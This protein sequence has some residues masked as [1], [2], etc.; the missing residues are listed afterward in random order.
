MEKIKVII[1]SFVTVLLSTVFYSCGKDGGAVEEPKIPSLNILSDNPMVSQAGGTATISFTCTEKWIA[2]SG[3][4]WI[5]ISPTNGLSGSNYI[6]ITATE[7]DS[8]DERN[9]NITITAGNITKNVT[10]TQKQKDALLVTSNKIEVK[11]EGG[12]ANIEVKTNVNY[13]VKVDDSCKDWVSVVSTRALS[14][15]NVTLKISE[16]KEITTREGKVSIVSGNLKED[17]SI[18]QNGT[19]PS[20]VLSQ[21]E[22][23]VSSEGDTVK[24]ELQS[25]TS[26]SV[27]MP[28]VDW[29]SESTTRAMSS[30]THY[31]NVSA[32][33]EYDSRSAK[34][35]FIDNE[36]NVSDTVKIIQAQKDAIIVANNDYNISNEAQTLEFEI[37]SNID[38]NVETSV[39]WIKHTQTR[40]LSTKKLSFSIDENVQD[41]NREGTI[42]IQSNGIK[43]T[44]NVKQE[45]A[46]MTKY[47]SRVKSEINILNGSITALLAELTI[48]EPQSED[49]QTRIDVL[50]TEL[51]DIQKHFPDINSNVDTTT[52]NTAVKALK[53]DLLTKVAAVDSIVKANG[54]NITNLRESIA[55]LNDKLKEAVANLLTLRNS[56]AKQI[57]GIQLHSA[58]CPVLS[59]T[60]INLGGIKSTFLCAY[61]GNNNAGTDEFYGLN[62]KKISLLSNAGN[63]YF[64]VQPIENFTGAEVKLINDYREEAP[65]QLTAATP[66]KDYSLQTG[67]SQ[68]AGDHV[69][70]TTA[71]YQTVAQAEAN[72]I[73]YQNELKKIASDIKTLIKKKQASGI[74][75]LVI[76]MITVAV[77]NSNAP[78]YALATEYKDANG[79]TKT[80]TTDLNIALQAVK[81]LAFILDASS[82][83]G[84]PNLYR[85]LPSLAETLDKLEGKLSIDELKEAITI[86]S[87]N[88]S[89]VT[90]KI[91]VDVSGTPTTITVDL[92]DE[93]TTHLSAKLASAIADVLND[94][95][96]DIAAQIEKSI[97]NKIST[98]IVSSK[99]LTDVHSSDRIISFLNKSIEF[100]DK[101]VDHINA[102]M[103]PVLFYGNKDMS[104]H[105]LSSLQSAPIYVKGSSMDLYASTYT[106]DILNPAFKKALVVENLTTGENVNKATF[107]NSTQKVVYDSKI[108][109]DKN[110]DG[111]YREISI[112]FPSSG[113]YKITYA[114]IDYFGNVVEIPYFVY[115]TI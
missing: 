68:A 93:S 86:K 58:T 11:T 15:C 36:N 96:T 105:H 84:N 100:L 110:F 109:T 55:Q 61:F 106:M 6:T 75:Q 76:D 32:N 85:S 79:A 66:M 28:G 91:T 8:Y 67:I 53:L 18:Y 48:V 25:N 54:V 3:A 38:F 17:V 78:A 41:E 29:I 102:Y 52:I 22:Y 65:V 64:S 98:T 44:I 95:T 63:M 33:E 94:P 50:E 59:G 31:F 43:Q 46:L 42:I 87:V 112:K 72:Q 1:L 7:N 60:S 108:G 35:I 34:I 39:D 104:Y 114:A 111:D 69:Y 57:T 2:T 71:Y 47:F 115:V 80:V 81:P 14:T 90:I 21:K 30:Y 92:G 16:N 99:N 70:Q 73:N 13:E 40:S 4:S 27:Q 10:V 12:D 49:D 89:G 97:N 37:Q 83:F 19:A 20:I 82:A 45:G 9:G 24:V 77:R 113:L 62:M 56:I 103:E 26:Y 107:I 101:R 5:S 23:T 51:N 74:K 88:L